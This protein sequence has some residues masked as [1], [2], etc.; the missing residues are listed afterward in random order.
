MNTDVAMD[1][2]KGGTDSSHLS[3]VMGFVE[4]T[5]LEKKLF[6]GGQGTGG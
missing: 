5:I 3:S 2:D 1:L 6:W 4:M